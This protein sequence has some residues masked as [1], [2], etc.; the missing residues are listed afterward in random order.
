M[1]KYRKIGN[2]TDVPDRAI[3]KQRLSCNFVSHAPGNSRAC[4]YSASLVSLKAG[5]KGMMACFRH[6]R[7]KKFSSLSLDPYIA[8]QIA[9]ERSFS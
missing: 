6:K 5:I 2:A 7:E 9:K 3:Y 8:N 1:T 4:F